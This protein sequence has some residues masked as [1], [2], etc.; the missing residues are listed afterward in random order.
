MLKLTHRRV[1]SPEKHIPKS[2]Y[3]PESVELARKQFSESQ[4]SPQSLQ[5]SPDIL[6]NGK[7]RQKK[8][9]QSTLRS[10]DSTEA[11]ETHAVKHPLTDTARSISSSL[12]NRFKRA[13]SKP[14]TCLPPQQLV[15][16]RAHFGDG[17]FGDIDTSDFDNYRDNE[18]HK[19]RRESVYD[20]PWHEKIEDDG[21]GRLAIMA[22]VNQSHGSLSASSRS[23]VTS[24]TNTTTTGSMVDAPLERKRLSVIQE[25]GGPHQPSSSTGSHLGGVSAFRKPLPLSTG[26]LPDPQRLYSAL[27]RRMNQESVD[28]EATTGNENGQP[29]FHAGKGQ[30]RT[31][32]AVTSSTAAGVSAENDTSEDHA[33]SAHQASAD[34][35]AA[36]EEA[37]HYNYSEES[38]YS[39]A[40][41]GNPNPNYR[42]PENTSE[43]HIDRKE[44]P[45]YERDVGMYRL[46]NGSNPYA[47]DLSTNLPP[48]SNDNI[49][50]TIDSGDTD[51]SIRGGTAHVRQRAARGKRYGLMPLLETNRSQA[52]LTSERS[53]GSSHVRE[54]AQINTDQTAH[55]TEGFSDNA[56]MRPCG[57]L[58]QPGENGDKHDLRVATPSDSVPDQLSVTKKRY[59]ML[60]VKEVA[61]NSTPAPS[62]PSSLTRSQSGLL[63]QTLDVEQG[64]RRKHENK[65]AA[66]LRK[67]SPD[68]VANL[69]RGKKS[70][71][72]L[73]HKKHEKENRPHTTDKTPEGKIATSTQA[74]SHLA[75]RSGNSA[76][77]TSKRKDAEAHCESPTDIV[78]ANLSARLS[79]PFDMDGVDFN[80]V[81]DSMYLG[82]REAGHP[83][84]TGGRVSVTQAQRPHN[85]ALGYD[86][87]QSFDRGPGGYGGL[88]PSPLDGHIAEDDEEATALPHMPTQERGL[89]HRPSKVGMSMASKRM[90]SNF[91]RSRRKA[92]SSEED[93]VS[94]EENVWDD[95]A[96]TS[97]PLFV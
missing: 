82:E 30:E 66:S 44:V 64:R 33:A 35:A 61:R 72:V 25:D 69:L 2:P 94:H 81:A 3:R 16:S 18:V 4:S 67:I 41:D 84:T 97:S 49:S 43:Q 59:P 24:W 9:F 76:G 42:Q 83:D 96:G 86:K 89:K 31:I 36:I 40:D 63:Q 74:S 29:S 34:I 80:R 5:M 53:Q 7:R 71:A 50:I 15:A 51:E 95:T 48:R 19:V 87:R 45:S 65:L 78:K 8:D 26:Q 54:L 77:A 68:N 60:N 91:L 27:V 93:A 11:K 47:T 57:V 62:R 46:A 73:G 39:R 70:L 88:G 23:R 38:V 79:R 22:P 1:T 92:V 12:R 17:I 58:R 10:S 14:E 52:S 85:H 28:R 37:Y 6:S 32:R 13:F 55:M 21:F 20:D 75:M 90:V 56:A